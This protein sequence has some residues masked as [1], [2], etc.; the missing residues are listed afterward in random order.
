MEGDV[1]DEVFELNFSAARNCAFAAIPAMKRAGEGHV[2]FIS[3]YAA[4][5]PAVGQAAYATAK[6]A[7]HGLTKELAKEYGSD[8]IRVNTVLPGFLETPMTAAVS[9]KRREVVK[10]L[11]FLGKLNTPQAAA[12]FIRFLHEQMPHTSGQIFS[13]DSRP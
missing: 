3:S 13:L 9:E 8:G 2:V 5:H 10:E 12:G 6:A 11:H 7:L 1:W 4:V